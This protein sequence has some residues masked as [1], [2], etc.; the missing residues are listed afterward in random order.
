MFPLSLGH[1]S[2]LN[3]AKRPR[4]HW[5]PEPQE[6]QEVFMTKWVTKNLRGTTSGLN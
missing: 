1:D 5:A 6:I 4:V 2:I 3:V